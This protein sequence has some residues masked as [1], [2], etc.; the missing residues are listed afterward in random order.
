MDILFHSIGTIYSPFKT[1]DGM[2]IQPAGAAG[3]KGKVILF[4]EFTKGLKDIESFSHII[5]IYH[6]HEAG[7]VR[8]EVTPFLDNESHGVFATRAPSRPNGIGL[9]VVRLL[10]VDDNIL[11]IENVDILDKTPLLDV[12]PYVP[13]FDIHQADSIGWLEKQ[14]DKV[15]SKRA[16]NR[17]KKG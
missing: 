10:G 3:I 14:G 8:L 11:N 13:K 7:E 12:K 1:I 6:F 9:S 2:P 16:D 4:H 17:F 15:Q 5:L